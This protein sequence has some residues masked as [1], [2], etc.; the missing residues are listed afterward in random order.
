M[1]SGVSP[2]LPLLLVVSLAGLW[3][4]RREAGLAWA[5][6]G[7]AATVVLAPTLLQPHGVPTSAGVLAQLPPWQGTVS[8]APT[9]PD[10]GDVAFQIQPWLV[11]LRTEL[12]AGRL[13]FWNPY[14]YAGA[15]FWSNGQSAPLFPLHWL[16]AL[17]PLEAGLVLLPWLRVVIGSLGAFWFARE[18]GLGRAG[19]GL[20]AVAFPLSGRLVSFLL[21][22]MANALCLVPWIFLAVERL[23]RGNVAAARWLAVLAGLQLVAGHPETAF[24]TALA[25][26]T[27]LLARGAAR[28][29]VA[30]R[31]TLVSWSVGALLA[32]VALVPLAMMVVTSSR[33]QSWEAPTPL[34]LAAIARLLLRF[35]LPDAYGHAVEGSYWGPLPFVPSTVY[36]GAL[37]VPLALAG[38]LAAA[39]RGGDRRLRALAWVVG[40][41]LVVSYHLPLVRELLLALPILRHMLHH[42][43]LVAVELGLAVLAGAG[44]ERWLAGERR[45]LLAGLA[46]S[47]AVLSL[48]WLTLA[49][50]WQ[51]HDQW[52]LQGTWTA[53]ALG[54][55]LALWLAGRWGQHGRR[56]VAAVA[57]LVTLAELAY[58]NGRSNPGLPRRDLYPSTPA[59]GFLAGKPGRVA[60]EGFALRPN[61]ATVYGLADVRGDDSLKLASSET[62]SSRHL[63]GGHPTYFQP[64]ERWDEG[65]LDRLGVR[66]VLA[67]PG[68]APAGP[69]WVQA[70]SGPDATVFER[71]T[72]LPLVRCSEPSA[73]ATLSVRERLPGRWRI[74]WW[75]TKPCSLVVAETHA[76][77]WSASVAGRAVAVGTADDVLLA[78][79]LAPGEGEISLRYLPPGLGWGL[80]ASLLGLSLL[81]LQATLDRRRRSAEPSAVSP[82][83]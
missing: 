56:R 7:L 83:A 45:E 69:G 22:P 32:G 25:T 23:A 31:R 2:L 73:E 57:V 11:F 65:W 77:G 14:Q 80:A 24:F 8:G 71:P 78:A 40:I 16:F 49:A 17:L 60:A 47:T 67:A 74:A 62:A 30:W 36:V 26:G 82:A 53:V 54:L 50:S 1:P 34:P 76:P 38:A 21:F 63:G 6:A 79:D 61:T 13:P 15:P 41:G 52:A 3:R 46:L 66:W 42:Y 68:A 5:L 12:R 70:Y 75:A 10:L 28:P 37:S 29:F 4:P 19:A 58:A 81:A 44:L 55:P 48:A 51:A 9:N 43:L 72:A 35:W 20:A 39:R 27:Y 59:L 64:I 33:W 18:L